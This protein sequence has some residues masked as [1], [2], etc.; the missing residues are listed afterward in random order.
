[1]VIGNAVRVIGSVAQYRS[2]LIPVIAH[3]P[4]ITIHDPGQRWIQR[5]GRHV[6]LGEV[7]VLSTN[8]DHSQGDH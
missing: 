2:P 3:N 4:G 1:L 5:Q 7:D 8:G 6:E